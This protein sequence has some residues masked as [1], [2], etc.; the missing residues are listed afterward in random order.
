MNEKNSESNDFSSK[1]SHP[2]FQTKS[3]NLKKERNK[4][5]RESG[6]P[7]EIA[8]RMSR[9]IAVTTGIPTISGMGVFVL[10]YYLI[11]EGIA[12]IPPVITLIS[13]GGCFLIGLLGLSYGILSASWEKS[14]G[15]LLG[16]ENIKPNIS[17]MKQ[18]FKA[19]ELPK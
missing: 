6:I 16:I 15:T 13:S 7:K 17:R 8:N 4:P 11:T 19:Q 9:R 5:K 12:E 14:T 2:G 10:S 18:A 1:I 3:Q